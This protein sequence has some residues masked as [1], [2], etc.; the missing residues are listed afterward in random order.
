MFTLDEYNKI[1]EELESKKAYLK[2]VKT[3]YENLFNEFES[4]SKK[5]SVTDCNIVKMYEDQENS[6]V[7]L[8]TMRE[9]HTPR[10]ILDEDTVLKVVKK[11]FIKLANDLEQLT[12]RTGDIVTAEINSSGLLSGIFRKLYILLH[13]NSQRTRLL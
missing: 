7:E 12:A 3:T 5:A 8:Y 6:T 4:D 13:K 10:P 9:T 11:K 1:Q 2:E